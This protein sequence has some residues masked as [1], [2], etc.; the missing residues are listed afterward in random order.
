MSTAKR[1]LIIAIVAVVVVT[2]GIAITI[3]SMS[4]GKAI[5]PGEQ[6]ALGYKLLEEGKYEEAILAFTKVISIDEKNIEARVAMSHAYVGLEQYDK[7]ESILSEALEIEPKSTIAISQ[8]VN[9]YTL[10]DKYDDINRLLQNLD[11]IGLSGEA[12]KLRPAPPTSN[13]SSGNYSSKL[14]VELSAGGN[15]V[16]YTLDGTTPSKLS[17]VYQTAIEIATPGVTQLK[18]VA[19]DENGIV[20]RVSDYSYNL[21]FPPMSPPTASVPSGDYDRLQNVTL[22]NSNAGGVILYSIDGSEPSVRYTGQIRIQAGKTT[23]RA[24]VLDESTGMKS[25]IASFSYNITVAAPTSPPSQNT[26]SSPFF[27][28][29][30]TSGTGYTMQKFFSELF[31]FEV[32]SSDMRGVGIAVDET[33]W[34]KEVTQSVWNTWWQ[35][36]RENGY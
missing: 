33:A 6:M 28:V 12:D 32:K 16:Y 13:I 14:S 35:W 9:V 30:T 31:G 17:E 1:S 19:I 26:N 15:D 7:A 29:Q 21:N 10:Q 34:N 2:I 11:A 20:S 25:T 36:A 22:S 18:A 27:N 8:M 4:G 23:L 5:N 24:I 3:V